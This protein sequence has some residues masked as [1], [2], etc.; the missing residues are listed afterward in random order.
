MVTSKSERRQP[1][2]R[3]VTFLRQATPT[4]GVSDVDLAREWQVVNQEQD[5]LLPIGCHAC[6]AKLRHI[7]HIKNKHTSMLAMIGSE[8]SQVLNRLRQG[9]P[10]DSPSV[11]ATRFLK[12]LRMQHYSD[13][14]KALGS[15]KSWR[16]WLL[17]QLELCSDVLPPL[18][19]AGLHSL[20]RFG[21]IS[22]E[23]QLGA[24]IDWHDEHR[25]FPAGALLGQH[26]CAK[27]EINPVSLMTIREARKREEGVRLVGVSL[28]MPCACTGS[29]QPSSLSSTRPE[30]SGAHECPWC[31]R[32]LGPRVVGMTVYKR[33]LLGS[34]PSAVKLVW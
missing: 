10:I 32:S 21:R 16:R 6:G 23:G 22:D 7:V 5:L 27:L 29:H 25:E 9:L 1:G 20:R 12:G 11:T 15:L 13:R 31:S 4:A 30:L 33:R 34:H 3:L 19:R 26:Q 14:R 2:D 24:C 18:T 28:V 17:Q 8:C